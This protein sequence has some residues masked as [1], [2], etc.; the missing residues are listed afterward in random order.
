MNINLLTTNA[1]A[2]A[3]APAEAASTDVKAIFRGIL[4]KL[5][6]QKDAS[7]APATTGENV[8]PQLQAGT[9]SKEDIIAALSGENVDLQLSATEVEDALSALAEM[10]IT[11]AVIAPGMN[12]IGASTTTAPVTEA[13]SSDE[14]AAMI[15]SLMQDASGGSISSSQLK[16]ELSANPQA[17]TLIDA[18][19]KSFA[20]LSALN[21]SQAKPVL[22]SPVTATPHTGAAILPMAMTETVSP[23]VSA[24]PQATAVEAELGTASAKPVASIDASSTPNFA[25]TPGHK[26]A[27]TQEAPKAI[28]LPTANVAPVTSNPI[29]DITPAAAPT[30]AAG[31]TPS[32]Q[33]LTASAMMQQSNLSSEEWKKELGENM[34]RMARNGDQSMSIKLN[35]AELGPL[36]VDM[37]VI[38]KQVQLNFA[39]LNVQVRTAIEQALPQLR[40]SLAEQGMNLSESSVGDQRQPSQREGNESRKGYAGIFNGA[41]GEIEASDPS[42]AQK[43]NG[44]QSGIDIYV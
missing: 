13:P 19:Y 33:P 26:L 22:T 30:S 3:T 42:V 40:E 11:D 27:T 4:A 29:A 12:S 35:P 37:K 25:A 10:T 5:Q 2:A 36:T 31:S 7:E 38:E 21:E 23:I 1:N 18:A 32:A 44:S 16:K 9:L 15:T 41:T 20:G 14:I 34:V 8:K 43:S 24:S 28:E 17:K 39:S 6:P